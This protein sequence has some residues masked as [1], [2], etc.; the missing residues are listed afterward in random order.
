MSSPD[1]QMAERFPWVPFGEPLGMTVEGEHFFICRLC[2][3]HN[4]IRADDLGIRFATREAALDHIATGHASLS[5]P[6]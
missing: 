3:A 4:G 2:L 6:Q 5:S 1:Q